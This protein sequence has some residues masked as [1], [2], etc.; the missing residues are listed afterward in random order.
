M[1]V[2][3]RSR[4]LPHI[5]VA[6]SFLLSYTPGKDTTASPHRGIPRIPRVG[7]PITLPIS[8]QPNTKS[9]DVARPN[10]TISPLILGM[11]AERP[12]HRQ[13]C[14]LQSAG[15][16]AGTRLSMRGGLSLATFL[17]YESSLFSDV[18]SF[19]SSLLLCN[20]SISEHE[21]IHGPVFS[22]A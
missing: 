20:T 8:K 2:G 14:T 18:H 3:R 11:Q 5:K 22:F 1:P 13:V 4:H 21:A 10:V 16:D 9:I 6:H 12:S 7:S 17:I 19:L 15:G